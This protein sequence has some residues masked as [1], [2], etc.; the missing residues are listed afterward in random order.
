MLTTLVACAS[1]YR[2]VYTSAEGDHYIEERAAQGGYFVPD[3]VIYANIGFD[4]WWITA[5][6]AL[7]FIYYNPNYYQYY[8]SAWDRLIYQ[9]YYVY[10]RG[11]YSYRCPPYQVRH[12]HVY[13]DSGRITDT[14][15]QAPFING[16]E[17]IERRDLWRSADRKSLNRVI[18]QS[19]GSSYKALDQNRSMTP[20]MNAP[21]KP[22]MSTPGIE[23]NRS[24]GFASPSPR[25][26]P[27]DRSIKISGSY[28]ARHKQ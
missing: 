20:F 11:D 19:N 2:T 9:P 3:S 27:V 26:I 22:F 13:A 18:N 23:L 10:G 8:L 21:T 28:R 6:P 4:P 12:G 1:P 24:S 25:S 17:K 15:L 14:S 16:R 5:N 7:S